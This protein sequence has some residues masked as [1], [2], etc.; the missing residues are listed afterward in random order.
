MPAFLLALLVNI[1]PEAGLGADP[2]LLAAGLAPNGVL[3]NDIVLL[4]LAILAIAEMTGTKQA[5]LR[6]LLNEIEPYLKPIVAA[7]MV[8][9]YA[10][11]TDVNAIVDSAQQ[12][13]FGDWVAA[14]FVGGSVFGVAQIR[15]S[16]LGSVFEADEDDDSGLQGI[17]SW[18]EDFWSAFGVVVAFLLPVLMLLLALLA[19]GSLWLLRRHLE[20]KE[21]QRQ[22][23]CSSCG[24]SM[25]RAALYCPSCDSANTDARGISWL[26]VAGA[27]AAEPDHPMRLR[28]FRRCPSCAER[29]ESRTASQVC[30][31]CGKTTFASGTEAEEYDRWV[32][33]RL[34]K[35]LVLVTLFGLVPIVGMIP[36][37]IYGRMTV[38]APYRRYIPRMKSM[39][40]RVGLR[41]LLVFAILFQFIPLL[42]T[43]LVALSTLASHTAYRSLFVKSADRALAAHAAV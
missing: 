5:D 32:R 22:V 15:S 27:A 9:A 23:E 3:T 19:I 16:V 31:A 17:L 14:T 26:G 7:A 38:V 13:G 6:M 21:V 37:V 35:T 43:V 39:V 40:I 41:V 28:S 1:S 2:A 33:S 30:N 12:A 20:N 25:Y 18:L 4:C 8:V 42:G 29:L 34:P 24:A 10:N 11:S 36:A